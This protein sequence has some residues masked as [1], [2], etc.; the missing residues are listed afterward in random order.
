MNEDDILSDDQPEKKS[1]SQVKRELDA[2]KD[3]G[4]Q[5]LPIAERNLRTLPM[6]P[7]L[8]EA[9]LHG[10]KLQRGALARHLRYIGGLITQEEDI[11]G[12]QR[13]LQELLQPQRR[14]VQIFHAIEEWRDRLIAGDEDLL[15]E[16]VEQH[17]ADRQHLRQLLRNAQKEQAENKPP[18]SAR[19]LFQY[20]RDLESN[21]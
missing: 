10:Q 3:L 16:L 4:K 20:L 14:Q 7:E 13:G 11:E 9:L 19:L 17:A 15:N 2:L 21:K 12:I 6:S 5:L 18:K 1:K 8:L